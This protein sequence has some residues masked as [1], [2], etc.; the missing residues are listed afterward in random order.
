MVKIRPTETMNILSSYLRALVAKISAM[1]FSFLG[2]CAVALHL[3]KYF[4]ILER[5][6]A[7]PIRHILLGILLSVE[8]HRRAATVNTK[9]RE[10]AGALAGTTPSSTARNSITRPEIPWKAGRAT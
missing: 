5:M 1:A 4:H 10:V 8:T 7:S 3:I 2:I 9:S 6:N